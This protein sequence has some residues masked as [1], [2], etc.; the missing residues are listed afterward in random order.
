MAVA[1]DGEFDALHSL[2]GVN[3]GVCAELAARGHDLALV[4]APARTP[5]GTG[6]PVPPSL[7]RLVGRAIPG[8]VTVRHRWPPNFAP[9]PGD[10][11]FALVQPWEYGR[12]P[13]AW[14]GPIL[15]VVDEVWAYSRSVLRAYLASGIPEDRLAL[16]PP[17][18]DPDAFRPGLDPLPLPTGK[19]VRLLFV[20]GTIAR[21][22]FDAL[23]AAYRRA[24]TRADDVC[25]VVKEFGA[26]T[27]YRGQTAGTAVGRFRADPA[28]PEL[29]Y[30]TED[31]PESDLP[32]LYAACDALVAPY[33]GEGFG[34][35]VLEAMACGKP[36]V[37][38]AGGPTD[39]FAP[40]AAGWRVP[41]RVEY[42][43]TEAVGGLATAG[44]PW[45][46]EPDVDALVNILLAVAADAG[47]RRER[48]AAA[49]RAALGWTW[50]RTAAAVEDRVRVL[51]TRTP[52]RFRRAAAAEA[53]GPGAPGDTHTAV[54]VLSDPPVLV[55][56]EPRGRPRVSLTMIV[57][58]EE[59]N[60]PACLSSVRDLV[61]EAVVVDTGSADRTRAVAEAF[62]A[63]VGEFRWVDDFAAARNAALDRATGEYAFW[64]DA[65]DR[66]GEDDRGKLRALFAGLTRG[67]DAYVLKCLCVA[68]RPG[69]GPGTAVDHVRVF[70]RLPGHRW[71]YRVHEQI[72]PALRA[73]GA[74]V[75][76]SGVTVRHVGYV[77]PAVRRRKLARD[78][79]LLKLDERDRP[80]DPFTLFNLG[81][82]YAELGDHRAAA[83]ALRRSLAGSH[84][85]DSIVRKLY[86]LLAQCHHRAGD[87]AAA[88]A[89]CA[90]GRGHYPDDAELLF[91]AAG[92]AREGGDFLA[93][94][95]LYRRLVEGREA[96]HFASVDAG[97]RA[98]K[99]RHNL[100][101]LLTETRRP[102]EAEG[103]WRAALAADPRFLP[104]HAGLGGLYARR[105]DGAG[106]RRQVAALRELGPEG[107][108]EAAALEARWRAAGGS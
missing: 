22:G 44:R 7:A 106:V 64:M 93:A 80:A 1:W 81:S 76:W 36:V 40:P 12:V 73:T 97:L 52:V 21:K 13:R 83:A 65:D 59:H 37:V 107:G 61:D 23:L 8:A 62:G 58:D 20:G 71:T 4:P 42:F 41:A 99:G 16:V 66:L 90:E 63:V 30:L 5:A 89:A 32:R 28:A 70:R 6:G 69:A 2:A 38:T 48:G 47:E 72:L 33:R 11:P 19:R 104:A 91:L 94:E 86:A 53:P 68:D 82:V 87:R 78:L 60:L 10:G 14:V 77:D 24:F 100:A 9:P 108:A 75:R 57:R 46:L 43:P 49:R 96:D 98:V 25:L 79:R 35:P 15:G 56:A 74:D 31:L 34:L 67:N 50:A 18:V 45:W 84:P 95:E 39:E 101:V 51:R 105:G 27:F 102:G 29:V 85:R 92:L 26:G 55:P 103:L 17:G 54:T 3:R 88:A